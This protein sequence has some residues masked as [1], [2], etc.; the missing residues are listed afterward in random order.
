[1]AAPDALMRPDQPATRASAL[2]RM[3]TP[4][5][6][7]VLGT[8]GGI[9]LGEA[10]YRG[11]Q[12][13][14][15][16]AAQWAAVLAD[17]G[18]P[19]VIAA[20]ALGAGAAIIARRREVTPTT[21]GALVGGWALLVATAVYYRLGVGGRVV[22]RAQSY[23]GFWLI[24][25]LAVGCM[26]GAAGAWW[27]QRRDRAAGLVPLVA[28]ASLLSG[29]ATYVWVA[30]YYSSTA[31]LAGLYVLLISAGPVAAA[32]LAPRHLR[33]RAAAIVL[34]LAWPATMA[35][36]QLTQVYRAIL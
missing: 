1:M 30:G 18:S 8:V 23:I 29:E 24:V 5:E 11:M 22:E 25:G 7:A 28:V 36:H 26:A 35:L 4:A 21:A 32:V 6:L 19:W 9:A 10:C 31:P 12:G 20:F 2:H 15:S 33:V 13:G 27:W 14:A 16:V 17:F 3:R 34:T